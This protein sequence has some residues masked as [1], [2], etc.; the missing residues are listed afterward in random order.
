MML[1][2]GLLAL[3]VELGFSVVGNG[4]G[5][6]IA[7]SFPLALEIAEAGLGSML[8][9]ISIHVLSLTNYLISAA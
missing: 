5:S 6:C 2:A 8:V 1:S 7:N 3:Q 4:C 9:T